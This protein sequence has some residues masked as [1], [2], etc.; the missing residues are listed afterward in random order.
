MRFFQEDKV[1]SS[2]L[3]CS[4][5]WLAGRWH[6]AS[7]SLRKLQHCTVIPSSLKPA[8]STLIHFF[9][10]KL[11]S[12]IFVS[13]FQ[14]WNLCTNFRRNIFTAALVRCGNMNGKNWVLTQNTWQPQFPSEGVRKDI[15]Q[16][17][18]IR[19]INCVSQRFPSQTCWVCFSLN[20]CPCSDVSAKRLTLV[21]F[22]D[23]HENFA[24]KQQHP[25]IRFLCIIVH[26]LDMTC[27]ISDRSHWHCS[28]RWPAAASS[29]DWWL[30]LDGS[31]LQYQ[32]DLSLVAEKQKRLSFFPIL[33]ATTLDT[34]VVNQKIFCFKKI[35]FFFVTKP[36]F[37]VPF[38]GPFVAIQKCTSTTCSSSEP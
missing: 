30:K 8:Y 19:T 10:R 5:H 37:C 22:I 38:A 3:I 28:R 27:A 11:S 32:C 15:S 23:L 17:K 24:G 21:N 33:L 9:L 1:F 7:Y 2:R 29:I 4:A 13:F 35:L 16:L 25:S 36:G 34:K 26:S 6:Y 20:S 14:R 12:G 31:L 18:L